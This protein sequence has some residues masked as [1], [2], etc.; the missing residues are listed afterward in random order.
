MLGYSLREGSS[1][2]AIATA[3][4]ERNGAWACSFTLFQHNLRLNGQK[5]D[6]NHLDRESKSR[7]RI[8]LWRRARYSISQ[9]NAN[10][11]NV[12]ACFAF[13]PSLTD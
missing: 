12:P 13:E 7:L 10:R 1:L 5:T 6:Q 9:A 8:I 4:I 3:C 2:V 11:P